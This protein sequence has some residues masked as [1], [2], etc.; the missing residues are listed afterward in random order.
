MR[1]YGK[2]GPEIEI[3]NTAFSLMYKGKCCLVRLK[4]ER[5]VDLLRNVYPFAATV[6]FPARTIEVMEQAVFVDFALPIST[7]SRDKLFR[8]HDWTP[9]RQGNMMLLNRRTLLL[10]GGWT[11]TASAASGQISSR[12]LFDGNLLADYFQIYLRDQSHPDL[13][14]DYTEETIGK[15]LMIGPYAAIVHTARNMIVPVSV[16]WH[17]ARPQPDVE[18]YQH[19]AEAS[20]DCP[21]GVLI[22]AGLT[23]Y[24]PNASRLAVEPG[25]LGVRANMSG[26]DTISEDGLEGNDRYLLQLW[27]S[28]QPLGLQV[29][30]SRVER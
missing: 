9:S 11:M 4:D 30:K 15:G 23:D 19:V 21:S 20:F 16:E 2:A 1:H 10:L 7:C 3:K 17:N 22:V 26:L 8:L 5:L 6:E 27:P 18:R 12:L 24:E 14:S 29:L 28:P 25:R 13:P